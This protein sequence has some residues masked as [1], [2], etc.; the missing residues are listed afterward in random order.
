MFRPLSSFVPDAADILSLEVEELAGV[1]L[2]H[3]NS[4]EGMYGNS[5]YQN[6]L[7]SQTNFFNAQ[8]P[9]GAGQ[10]PEFGDRQPEINRALMEAWSWLASE[11]FLIRDPAQS[12]AWFFVSRRGQRLKSRDDFEAYR[13]A[14]M[15]PRGQLHPVIAS[16][17]YPAFLRGK[18]DTAIF[19]AFREVEVAVREAGK[20][21]ATDY[22]TDL[23]RAAF[24]PAEKKGQAVTPGPLT[25]TRLPVA[26]QEAMANLFAGAI[27]LYK[28]P[29]SHR[30]VP[31]HAEDAAEVVVFASQLLRIVDRLLRSLKHNV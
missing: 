30:H 14:S 9:T 7:I 1:L 26:E 10:K 21:G 16:E 17:V 18:Y 4:Y 2:M 15:L 31:T 19:E 5:V 28:N 8:S 24:R 25:D 27:G 20:F 22:G 12:A 6:G 29:Q 11:G 13:M 3:L 23:M